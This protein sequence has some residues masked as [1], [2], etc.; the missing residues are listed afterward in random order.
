MDEAEPIVVV[1]DW[2][3]SG[4]GCCYQMCVKL[5]SGDF[6]VIE[7]ICTGD[8]FEREMKTERWFKVSHIFDLTPGM[9]VRHVLSQHQGLYMNGKPPGDGGV[10][11]TQS[12]LTIGPYSLD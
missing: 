10:K 3:Y 5:L 2:F 12:R 4:S 8:V 1:T 11:I 9:G 6:S 7:E